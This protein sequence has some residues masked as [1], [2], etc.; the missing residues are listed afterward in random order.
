MLVQTEV[1][2]QVGGFDRRM[3]NTKEHL[4]FCLTVTDAGGKIYFEPASIATYVPGPPLEWT[5]LHFFMLRWSD[6]WTLGSLNHLREKWD[7]SEDGYFKSK[8]KKLG[9]RRK[10]TIVKPLSKRLSF[11][12]NHKPLKELL[13][14]WERSLNHYLTD[15][16]S[17]QAIGL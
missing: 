9:W 1:C 4:D 10:G 11:G 17:R 13:T 5:D 2:R 15:R 6:A 8:Y 3:L 14:T 7:L 12:F 16:H